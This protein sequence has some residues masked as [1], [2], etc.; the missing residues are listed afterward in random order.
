MSPPLVSLVIP[1]RNA[2]AWLEATLVSATT[3]TWARTE[4]VLVDDGSTDGSPEI[5]RRFH[6]R[7]VRLVSGR[8]RGAAAARNDGLKHAAGEYLQFLDADDLLAA[9]KIERQM[10]ALAKAAG[11]A[12]ATAAWARFVSHPD[13]AVFRSDGL[14]STQP[15]ID[16][17]VRSW[18]D[19]VMMAT[20]AWL[21]PRSL[22]DRA[23]PWDETLAPN[24]VDDMEYFSRVLLLSSEVVF[25]PDARVYYR[26]LVAGSLSRVRTDEAWRSVFRSFEL[27]GERLLA[28][29]DSPR[30][31]GAYAAQ[32]QRLVYESYPRMAPERR[33]AAR[34]IKELGGTS[35]RPEAGA[36]HRLVQRLV[37]WKLAKRLYDVLH[38]GVRELPL[39]GSRFPKR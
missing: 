13:E 22:A 27:T 24:P 35:V 5:A 36:R 32:L 11:G 9:D 16:W 21:V 1:C 31:R 23:G 8:S 33:S 34:R 3:Q 19:H 2:A 18:Q 20:A 17:L 30:T 10:A 12:V 29:E 25:C 4:T 15:P 39:P 26:S 14:W 37:G 38:G 7:G 6:D 28:R